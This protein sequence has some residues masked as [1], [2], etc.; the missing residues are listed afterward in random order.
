MTHPAYRELRPVTT[1]ASVLLEDNPGPMTLD[2]TNTWLLRAPGAAAC[3]VVDPGEDDLPHLERVAAA[4]GAVSLVLITHWHPDHVGGAPWLAR[5]TGAPVRA[6]DPALTVGGAPLVD[7]EVIE[8]A[9]VR[10]QVVA[11]PGHTSDSVSFLL[12]GPGVA[13]AVLTGDTV[14]GRGTTVIAHPDGAL[15]PY[16]TSL[17]RLAELAPDTV[18]LPG[19]GPE[20][21]DAAAAATAYLAHREQRLDQVRAALATLGADASPPQV[22]E[23][24][25]VDV[26]RSLWPAAELS[27]RAQL[28]YLRGA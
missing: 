10:L 11:T 2:G 26:D 21:P 27:V 7:G 5:Q 13:P 15:G 9:G 19:H 3:V 6:L 23:H 14:L 24:V 17:R 12:D 20:L 18:A 22:V 8:A 25:Y 1:L 28:D 16:L 4:A